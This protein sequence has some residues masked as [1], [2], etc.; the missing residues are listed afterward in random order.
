MTVEFIE[1]GAF[2]AGGFLSAAA[3]TSEEL[4]NSL[5]APVKV[6]T[7]ELGTVVV[8]PVDVSLT[9]ALLSEAINGTGTYIVN[10]TGRGFAQ[11]NGQQA[12]INNSIELCFI[13]VPRTI[14]AATPNSTIDIC[15]ASIS[16]AVDKADVWPTNQIALLT[17]TSRTLTVQ[18]E[19]ANAN[20]TS[21]ST[22][23]VYLYCR[24]GESDRGFCRF[25]RCVAASRHLVARDLL[26]E[27]E[28]WKCFHT[29][30]CL[31]WTVCRFWC[32]ALITPL[33]LAS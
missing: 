12:A 1:L 3:F 8:D 33:V 20:D 30:V 6:A 29:P 32:Q 28:C 4:S 9:S 17:A 19:N 11:F 23:T 27:R 21:T 18:I 7:V 31:C 22:A 2:N 24:A 13:R 16:A 10:V 15:D 26:D 14:P 25:V 5:P